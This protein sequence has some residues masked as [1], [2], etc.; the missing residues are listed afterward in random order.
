LGHEPHN[1]ISV[2]LVDQPEFLGHYAFTPHTP[3][4]DVHNTNYANTNYAS[5][6]YANNNYANNNYASTN[7]ANTNYASNTNYAYNANNT[8]HTSSLAQDR[9]DLPF[10]PLMQPYDPFLAQPTTYGGKVQWETCNQ[11]PQR[12]TFHNDKEPAYVPQGLPS[13]M[14][15]TSNPHMEREVMEHW[16]LPIIDEHKDQVSRYAFG[17]YADDADQVKHHQ[18]DPRFAHDL[19]GQV[20]ADMYRG[21]PYKSPFGAIKPM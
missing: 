9:H 1:R 2:P 7:Y 18:T 3:H 4:H 14:A 16:D 17:F 21:A 5:N 15:V 10:F 12:L 20:L 19:G 13:Y 11:E 6:N 8:N